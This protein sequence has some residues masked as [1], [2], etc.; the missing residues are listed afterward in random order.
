MTYREPSIVD[1]INQRFVPL[2]VNTTEAASKPLV[3]RYRQVWTPD[4]RVLG[5]DGFEFYRWNGYLPPSEFLPQL[6]V[7]Q[8]QAC[9]RM[10]DPGGAAAIY[11]DVLRRFP[12][13][14]FAP[15]AEYYLAVCKYRQSHEGNDLLGGWRQ[16]QTRYPDS[17]WRVKQSFIEQR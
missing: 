12:T 3:E 13:S 5:A 11:E 1:T 16:V 15:E 9:L 7:A 8:A 17:I 10:E 14:A 6:L 4:V 2:Q